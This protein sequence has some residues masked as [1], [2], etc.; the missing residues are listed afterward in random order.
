MGAKIRVGIANRVVGAAIQATHSWRADLTTR[1]L[2]VLRT[3]DILGTDPDPDPGIWSV[4]FKMTTKN[5]CFLLI[6]L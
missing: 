3:R 2:A 1:L 6:T 4:T 5:N